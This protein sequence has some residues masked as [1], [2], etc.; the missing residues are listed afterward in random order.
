MAK[1]H[2]LLILLFFPKKNI[3]VWQMALIP[4]AIKGGNTDLYVK[5]K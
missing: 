4:N 3:G 2:N 1:L 5:Y